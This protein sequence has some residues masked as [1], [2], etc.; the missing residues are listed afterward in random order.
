[1]RGN[2]RSRFVSA[3]VTNS[4]A[5]GECL[6]WRSGRR[7]RGQAELDRLLDAPE[8]HPHAAS[9]WRIGSLADEA[10]LDEDIRKGCPA[11]LMEPA[12]CPVMIPRLTRVRQVCRRMSLDVGWRDDG[13]LGLL[14]G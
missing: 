1:M 5:A 14:A 12:Q 10:V 3:H 8:T 11:D 2:A 6:G 7:A 13:R 9:A 4:A